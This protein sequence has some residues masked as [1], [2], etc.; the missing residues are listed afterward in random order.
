MENSADKAA[1]QAF[2]T[3]Q[4][5]AYHTYSEWEANKGNYIDITKKPNMVNKLR[6]LTLTQKC[7]ENSN[8]TYN[9]IG[10]SCGLNPS[11]IGNIEDIILQCVQNQ[12]IEC[13]IDQRNRVIHVL[14]VNSG[15]GRG[16]D[17][18]PAKLPELVD[19]LQSWE[20]NQ[21]KETHRM[22]QKQVRE[23]L[24]KEV[25]GNYEEQMATQITIDENL[26]EFF[27]KS[28]RGAG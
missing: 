5:Y 7:M 4:L 16:R 27:K 15:T 9:E 14:N 24:D 22:F 13:R 18:P 20:K 25:K 12:L 2:H 21:L 8:L 11:N 26:Q 3:L 6:C 1:Q 28:K 17:V 19:Q 10:N 23:Y